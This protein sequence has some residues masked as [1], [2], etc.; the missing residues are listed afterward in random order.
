MHTIDMNDTATIR[1]M[2]NHL[3]PLGQFHYINANITNI[4][5]YYTSCKFPVFS[6]VKERVPILFPEYIVNKCFIIPKE[7]SDAK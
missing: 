7:T 1:I 5:Y 3:A 6:L 2:V 4:L